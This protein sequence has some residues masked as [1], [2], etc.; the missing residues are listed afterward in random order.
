VYIGSRI[1]FPILPSSRELHT[2]DL[3]DSGIEIGP[4]STY[5]DLRPEESGE[6]ESESIR[7]STPDRLLDTSIWIGDE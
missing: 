2:Q 1:L 5:I 7:E 3:L 4:S 6:S